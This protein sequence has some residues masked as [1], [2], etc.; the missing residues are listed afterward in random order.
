MTRGPQWLRHTVRVRAVPV[1]RA[2]VARGAVGMLLPLALGQ[3]AGRPDLGAAAALGAYGAVADDSSA[4]WRTRALTLLLPQLG[5]AIGLALGRLT[6]GEAWA[7]ILLVALVAL[8]SGLMSTVGRISDMTAL[9]LLLATA[10]GLGLPTTPPWWQVPLLFLLGGIPLMLLS[11]ADALRHPGRAE[12]RAV[13]GAVRS[14][15]DLLEATEGTW[16]ERRHR[17]TEAMDAAYDTVIVRRLSAP[18]PGTTAARLAGRLESLVEVIAAAPAMKAP[19]EYPDVVRQVA[20]AVEADAGAASIALPPVPK[21]PALRALH[22]AVTALAQPDREAAAGQTSLLPSRPTL[23][24]RLGDALAARI[25]DPVARRYALRLTACLATAQAVASFSGL[26]HSGWLVLTV[27][28]V[29]RPGLG[30]V[31]ARLVTRAVGTIA[32]VLIGL[33]VIALCPAGWWRIAATVVLTGLLQAYARRNY[34]LQTLFLTPVMLLL[35]DP[36]GQAGSTVPQARLLDTVIGCAVAFVVGYLLWPEDSR[37][38]VDHRLANAHETI[39]A[40]ADALEHDRDAGTLHTMRRRIHGDLAAVRNELVRLRTDPRHHHTL[41]ARQD[42]LAYADAAITRLTSLAA[43]SH[44]GTP[45]AAQ[46]MTRDLSAELRRRA[47]RLR[48][49]RPRRVRSPR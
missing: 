21:V 32:G 42:E 16:T 31:P 25:G 8:V 40:Y 3:A 5:G 48:E 4:P 30:T 9:V 34:A 38:R 35:A 28:L 46:E 23:R 1:D 6:G 19:A 26:P 20:A 18:R 41:R 15:A 27:A 45:P 17:V 24:R 37:A 12:R 13:V 14:V 43:T 36:L 11:L 2:L 29:V 49:H 10:M 44:H 33:A 22:A 47:E 7:Q 39:A